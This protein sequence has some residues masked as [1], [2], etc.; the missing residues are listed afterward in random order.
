MKISRV[1]WALA[2]ALIVLFSAGCKKDTPYYPSQA[3]LDD[4]SGTWT[5]SLTAF[6][7]NQVIT[8]EGS[9][10]LYFPAGSDRLEGIMILDQIFALT[11]I[12]MRNGIYYFQVLNPDTA[13]PFCQNW[14]LS[15]FGELSSAD[16]MHVIITGKECG[17]AGEEWVNYEGDFVLSS[18]TPDSTRYYSFAGMNRHWTYS[19]LTL[20]GDSCQM[21]Y[22]LTAATGSIYTGIVSNTCSLPWGSMPLNWDVTP[23]HFLVLSD[24]GG[25][26]VQ[27]AFHIDQELNVPY[28][29]YPADD[30]NIVTLLGVDSVYVQA[31]G[32][33]C[34]RFRLERRIHTDSTYYIDKGVF[35]L[36]N[37]FGLIK[38]QAT[39][40][41]DTNDIVLQEL[42]QKNF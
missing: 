13:N 21:D 12:Q 18:P 39:L 10:L 14:N 9:I 34:S 23:M 26:E 3:T 24:Q 41:N 40:L 17:N 8:K 20:G 38:Y 22:D 19:V 15:G 37:S 1:I 27:Y 31:G 5:G 11:E 28:H 30:T 36:S 2:I 7:N 42:V 16:K 25:S 6:K 4:F 35:C 32:F 33:I 29:Y